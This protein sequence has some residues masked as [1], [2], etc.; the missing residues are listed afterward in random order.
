MI[1]AP[2]PLPDGREVTPAEAHTWMM[3]S[4][5]GMQMA[6]M[7]PPASANITTKTAGMKTHSMANMPGM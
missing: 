6:G 1:K 3:Q 7:T 2:V 5:P 4:M